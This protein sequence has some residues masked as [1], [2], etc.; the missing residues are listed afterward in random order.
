[1]KPVLY[2][3]DIFPKVFIENTEKLITIKPLGDHAAFTKDKEYVIRVFKVSQSNPKRYPERGG[4]YA[5]TVIPD[6][7]GSAVL[8]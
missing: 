4:K 1:M 5:F 6:A 7:D 2:N 3:Y 8:Y